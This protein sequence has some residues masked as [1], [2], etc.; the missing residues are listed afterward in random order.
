MAGEADDEQP[1]CA[2]D[3]RGGDDDESAGDAGFDS[4]DLPAPIAADCETDIDGAI[5]A[6]PSA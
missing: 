2:G 1:R 5:T 6:S 4:Y 3:R